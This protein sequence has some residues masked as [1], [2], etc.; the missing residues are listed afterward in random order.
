MKKILSILLVC[1][2]TLSVLSGCSNSTA[3]NNTTTEKAADT[4]KAGKTQN[5]VEV[6]FLNIFTTGDSEVD[7]LINKFNA[8]QSKV[9][10]TPVF[11]AVKDYSELVAKY[12][13]YAMT[14]KAPEITIVGVNYT[15]YMIKKMPIAPVSDFIGKENFDTSDFYPAMLKL[16]QDSAG[17]QWM[18]P[19]LISTPVL[20]YN[21]KIFESAGLDPKNP[22]A[23]YNKVREYA[24]KISAAGFQ[25]IYIQ[26]TNSWIYQAIVESMGGSMLSADKKNVTF[27]S[28]A[29]IKALTFISDLV[30]TDHSMIYQDYLQAIQQFLKGNLGM[31]MMSSAG[32]AT[33]AKNTDLEVA[34]FPGDGV[35]NIRVA[36]GGNCLCISKSTPEKEAAAWE[37]V[38]YITSAESTAVLSKTTGYMST[39]KRATEKDELLGGYLKNEPRANVTYKQSDHMVPMQN[40]PGSNGLKIATI[41]DEKIQAVLSG[42]MAPKDALNSAANEIKPLLNESR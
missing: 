37:F 21:K 42:S 30:N 41:V 14:G 10:V 34:P 5:P 7:K 12:Q 40:Y 4:D 35:H 26:D 32:F 22:P 11:A 6:S 25:G 31:V 29:G 38:K 15:D 33:L 3:T 39:S 16:G 19:F 1:V 24:K 9:K 18:L 20:Y 23:T 13:N 28:D 17:K 8:S 27:N 2:I 36:A